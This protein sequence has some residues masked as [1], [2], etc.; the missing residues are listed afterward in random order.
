MSIPATIRKVFKNARCVYKKDEIEVALDQ[1][2]Q[3]IHAEM[4]ELNPVLLTVLKGGIVLTGNLLPRLDFPLEIDNIYATRYQGA[5]QGFEEARYQGAAEGFNIVWKY[6]PSASLKDRTVLILDDILDLGVTL[7]AI[8][9]Y[10]QK[11]GASKI[12]TAVLLNKKVTR[13]E[14]G[15]KNADFVGLTIDDRYVFGYGLDYQEYLRNAPGIYEVAE[16]DQ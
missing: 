7:Q 4:S 11:K 10:C 13:A 8:V 1:M 5:F 9:E 12:Y 16:E 14:K 3:A 2:A 15:L 6:E